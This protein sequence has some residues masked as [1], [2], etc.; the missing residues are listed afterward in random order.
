MPFTIFELPIMHFA[1]PQYFKQALFS[2]SLATTA[3]T[4][5]IENNAYAKFWRANKVHYGQFAKLIAN[6]S[7]SLEK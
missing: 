5:E 6:N 3:T 7:S 4:L 2:I 1:C